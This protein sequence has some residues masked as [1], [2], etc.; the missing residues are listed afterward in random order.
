M[1]CLLVYVTASLKSNAKIGLKI[2]P[3]DFYVEISHAK[4]TAN[5]MIKRTI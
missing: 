4:V 5:T 2:L 1:N 3:F